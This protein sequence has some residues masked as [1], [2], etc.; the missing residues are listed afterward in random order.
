MSGFIVKENR[1]FPR[2]PE[3]K[4]ILDHIIF[5]DQSMTYRICRKMIIH[6]ERMKVSE[7]HFLMQ[8]L[9]P[10]I[11]RNED[12]LS[13]GHNWPSPK[14]N[15]FVANIVIVKV[16]EI[17]DK[18]IPDDEITN[19]ITHWIHKEKL[20]NLSK[21]LD[22]RNAP[23]TEVVDALKKYFELGGSREFTSEDERIG[24]RVSI[25]TRFLSENLR[26]ITIAKNF[27]T[28]LAIE[29]IFDRF[30]GPSYGAG[31]VGGKSAGMILANEILKNKKQINPKLKN[32]YT[33]RSWFLT[34]DGILEFINYNALDEFAFSKYQSLDEIKI[35]YPFLEYVFKQ[36]HFTPEAIYSFSQI[37]DDIKSSPIVVRSSSLLEDSFEASFTGKYKSLFLSNTGTK[38]ERLS[39]LMD[40]ISEV[41][42]STFNPDAIEY[43]K[44][45]NLI[46]FREEM[47]VLIQEVVGNKIGKYFMASYAGVALSHN[48]F[49]WSNRINR[50]DGVIRIVAGLGTRAVDRTMDDYPILISPG[51]PEIKVNH[52]VKDALKYTQRYIDVINLESKSF[53]NITVEELINESKGNIPAIEKI[54]SFVKDNMLV[55]PISSMADFTKEELTITFNNLIQNTDFISQIREMLFELSE[56]YGGPVDIEFASDGNKLY[57]LQCRPQSQAEVDEVINIPNNIIE[58][59]KIFSAN[60]FVSN[61]LI[62]NIDFVVYVDHEGYSSLETEED[63]RYIGKIVSKLNQMLPEKK[64]ILIGPG[65]WGS[66]GDI[67]LGVP[68][69]YSDINRTALLVEYAK[70]KSDYVPEL[71]FGTHFFQDLVEANIKYLPLYPDEGNLFN[72]KFFNKTPNS[73]KNFIDVPD[74]LLNIVKLIQV[75]YF[76]NN[77]KMMIYMNGENSEAVGIV[78]LI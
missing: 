28:L 4:I 10:Q 16:F 38:S 52:T 36:S 77:G 78:K 71:S 30:I 42:A 40:A 9:N 55:E 14:G 45:N 22:R 59:H 33:P 48:E 35:E 3:W 32:V 58:E 2:K 12:I 20:R 44:K 43:R 13:N 25:I 17:A 60:K 23:L 18:Y 65:R 61:G 7:I 69:N 54:F 49:R 70:K 47:G 39:A 34:S 27:I 57:L 67:K 53:E 56:A 72:D 26:Y 5:Q 24:V 21:V 29:K 19:L 64:F 63:M 8:E 6:L 11:I 50:E 74:K 73:L 15:P 37:L 1:S 76:L 41:Y 31:K 75:N 62:D 51:K 66:K 68:I 46:D